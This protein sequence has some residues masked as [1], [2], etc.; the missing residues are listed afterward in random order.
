M[1]YSNTQKLKFSILSTFSSHFSLSCFWIFNQIASTS[2]VLLKWS[3]LHTFSLKNYPIISFD[4]SFRNFLLALAFFVLEVFS[5]CIQGDQINCTDI[6]VETYRSL[7]TCRMPLCSINSTGVTISS[8]I[9]DHMTK[10]IF[11][12]NKKVFYLPEKV[13]EVYPNLEIYSAGSCSIVAISKNNFEKLTKLK[14]LN[15]EFNNIER[16]P[17]DVF[18][19]LFSLEGIFLGEKTLWI[20]SYSALKTFMFQLPTKLNPSTKKLFEDLENCKQ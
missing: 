6:S 11:E 9:D 14:E 4:R 2:V 18:T 12:Y 1:I 5:S 8:Q 15:L 10:I 20:M 7:K 17:D 19:D 13:H 16:I 3:A